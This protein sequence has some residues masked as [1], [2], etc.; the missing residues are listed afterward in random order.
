MTRSLYAKLNCRTVWCQKLTLNTE[1]LQ[2]LEFWGQELLNFNRHLIWPRPSAVRFAYSNASAT[3]YHGYIVERG[4][5]VTN[6]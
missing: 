3:G 4:N 2:E 5:L 1:A 6:G